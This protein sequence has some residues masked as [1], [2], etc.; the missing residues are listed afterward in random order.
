MRRLLPPGSLLPR[1]ALAGGLLLAAAASDCRVRLGTGLDQVPSDVGIDT[2][3]VR[4][5]SLLVT[6][7]TIRVDT[8][9]AI[10][11]EARARGRTCEDF[12]GCSGPV[13]DVDVRVELR[14]L[15]DSVADVLDVRRDLPGVATGYVRGRTAGLTSLVASARTLRDSAFTEIPVRVRVP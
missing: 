12:E 15:N 4:T 7:D 9:T 3:L 13:R 14:T 10:F 11:V 8:G 6:P 1:A 2:I 5:G